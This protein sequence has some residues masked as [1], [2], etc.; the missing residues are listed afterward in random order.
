MTTNPTNVLPDSPASHRAALNWK[1]LLG[2]FGILFLIALLLDVP[3]SSW[4]HDTGIAAFLKDHRGLTLLLRIPGRWPGVILAIAFAVGAADGT[5]VQNAALVVLSAAFSGS[6]VI[7]K[8]FFGRIRP[9]HGDAPFQLNLFRG[10]WLGWW[11]AEQNLSFPSGD[12]TL[13]FALAAS[14]VITTPRLR[15]LW[16]SLATFV[17]LERIAEGAHYPTDTVAGAALGVACALVAHHLIKR[18]ASRGEPKSGATIKEMP[19][20]RSEA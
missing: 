4:M 13:A 5:Q 6:N 12:A 9:F 19:Q 1:V 16:W 8:W 18:I 2:L 15:T 7:F 14:L 17:A 11:S 20:S 3:L 10:G